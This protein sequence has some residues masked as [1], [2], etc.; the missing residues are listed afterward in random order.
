MIVAVAFW[1]A[2]VVLWFVLAIRH[3]ATAEAFRDTALQLA[4]LTGAVLAITLWWI[5]HNVRIYR[6]KGPRRG[7]ASEPPVT[8]V[9]RLG[10]DIRWAMPGGIRTAR[11][12]QHLVVELDG[13][14]K[15][16]RRA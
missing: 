2:L 15:V 6:R 14:T 13:E 1:L 11:A 9:D 7:R 4:A 12:Q 8:D 10:R 16:V 5:N 3:R